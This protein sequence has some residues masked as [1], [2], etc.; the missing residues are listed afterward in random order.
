M[1]GERGVH[2]ISQQPIQQSRNIVP[3]LSH[4]KCLV[5][6]CHPVDRWLSE[7]QS[8]P[9]WL[10]MKW[11]EVTVCTMKK[12]RARYFCVCDPCHI[13]HCRFLGLCSWNV[14]GSSVLPILLYGYEFISPSSHLFFIFLTIMPILYI[15]Y[16]RYTN[17]K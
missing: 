1:V 8:S 9:A 6:C 12:E 2:C 3:K 7:P 14:W 4:Y 10:D 17:D 15:T 11:T 13:S 5:E 16:T